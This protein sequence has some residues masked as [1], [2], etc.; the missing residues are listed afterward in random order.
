MR[1]NYKINFENLTIV[2]FGPILV[3]AIDIDHE[4]LSDLSSDKKYLL[5]MH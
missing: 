5:E 4:C 3:E 2:D 1:K